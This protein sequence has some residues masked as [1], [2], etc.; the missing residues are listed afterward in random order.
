MQVT[1]FPLN[2]AGLLLKEF[3]G[4]KRAETT[5][6]F[7]DAEIEAFLLKVDTI[8]YPSK[9]FSLLTVNDEQLIFMKPI[10]EKFKYKLLVGDIINYHHPN[11]KNY[12]YAKWKTEEDLNEEE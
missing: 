8:Y 12:I 3:G 6:R 1:D 11:S 2:C 4:T 9:G 10:L 7:S 5:I